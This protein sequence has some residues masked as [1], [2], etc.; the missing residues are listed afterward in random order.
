MHSDH[1]RRYHVRPADQVY[2]GDR[3]STDAAAIA[4]LTADPDADIP[5]DVEA[6]AALIFDRSR[7]TPTSFRFSTASGP[8]RLTTADNV[9]VVRERGDVLRDM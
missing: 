4:S 6:D 8:L 3:V 1:R 5:A 7:R 2:P 9:L